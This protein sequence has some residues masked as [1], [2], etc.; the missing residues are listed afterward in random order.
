MKVSEAGSVKVKLV[1]CNSSISD[2]NNRSVMKTSMLI[3]I[4]L[5]LSSRT[6]FAQAGAADTP[7]ESES[8]THSAADLQRALPNVAY[9]YT[10]NGASYKTIG[11]QAYGLGMAARD[12]DPV[13]GGGGAVWGSPVRRLTLIVDVHRNASRAFSPSAAAIVTMYQNEGFTLGALGKFKIDGFAGGPDRDEGE[14]EV[15]IGGLASYGLYGWYADL[16][17]IGG[18]GTGDDGE[19]DVEGRLRMGRAV[20]P[21]LRV[22]VDGQAR[23]RIAGPRY[24]PNGRTWDFVGGAQAIVNG[25]SFFGSLTAGPTTTGLLSK[26]VG[27]TV[28]ASVGGVAF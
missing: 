9:A 19:T 2:P 12:Q 22:G 23:V 6:A 20:V 4:G 10:A 25:N 13:I 8:G 18:R 7:S 16:N 5:L 28:V 3:A 27:W 21:W 24:L 1:H 15:E 17:A 14:S 26:N 11:L